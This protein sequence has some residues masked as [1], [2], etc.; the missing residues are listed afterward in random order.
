[1]NITLGEVTRLARDMITAQAVADDIAAQA[2]MA[3]AKAMFI[4]DILL[5]NTLREVGLINLTLD[6]GRVVSVVQNIATAISEANWP[7]AEAW[8]VKHDRDGIIKNQVIA[9]FDKG[10]NENAVKMAE[11]IQALTTRPRLVE[12]IYELMTDLLRDWS[13]LEIDREALIEETDLPSAAVKTRKAVHPQT[14]KAEIR[15]CMSIGIDVP[16]ETFSIFVTDHCKAVK[17][18]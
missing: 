5:P 11:I 13:T 17:P 1:M 2:Q 12:F 18:K 3:A 6:D 8:L 16:E 4:S 14:L 9:E 7:A 15:K 10:Q